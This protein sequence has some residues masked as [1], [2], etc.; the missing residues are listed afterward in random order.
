MM[1]CPDCTATVP[2]TPTW[3][4]RGEHARANLK[5]FVASTC[6]ATLLSRSS[7]SSRVDV[8]MSRMS[9]VYSI[10]FAACLSPRNEELNWTTITLNAIAYRQIF[11]QGSQTD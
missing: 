2:P 11:S 9:R 7:R 1:R 5:E 4:V 8:N 10:C 3:L 6:C